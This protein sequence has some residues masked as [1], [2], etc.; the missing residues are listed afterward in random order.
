[1]FSSSVWILFLFGDRFLEEEIAMQRLELRIGY[2]LV[3]FQLILINY[4]R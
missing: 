2:N 1:M 4:A 3:I